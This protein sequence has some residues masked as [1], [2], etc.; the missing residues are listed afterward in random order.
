MWHNYNGTC[1][2]CLQHKEPPP[3]PAWPQLCSTIFNP[4]HTRFSTGRVI[5]CRKKYS[6]YFPHPTFCWQSVIQCSIC[7]VIDIKYYF[8]LDCHLLWCCSC[9]YVL[10]HFDLTIRSRIVRTMSLGYCR[11]NFKDWCLTWPA[12]C[13]ASIISAHWSHASY[14]HRPRKW[15]LSTL[16]WMV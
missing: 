3:H 7:S 2:V 10:Y 12:Q 16:W 14:P 11:S 5:F 9:Y 1:C 15:L 8:L 6:I 4:K 13:T